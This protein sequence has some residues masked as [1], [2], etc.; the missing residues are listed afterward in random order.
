MNQLLEILEPN[1]ST[2]ELRSVLEQLLS[3]H[4]KSDPRIVR[5]DRRPSQYHSSFPIEELDVEVDDGLIL[6]LILKNLSAE[7]LLEE[8][9]RAKPHLI[10]NPR[11]AAEVYKQILPLNA[12][13]TATIY[14]AFAA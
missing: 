6:Q 10:R 4:F 3:E 14:G 13:V 9:R 1:V 12:L 8:A 2:E 5:I 7:A 11:R